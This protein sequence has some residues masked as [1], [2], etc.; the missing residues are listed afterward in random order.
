MT[1]VFLIFVVILSWYLAGVIHSFSLMMYS[2]CIVIFMFSMYIITRIYK[3]NIE[4]AFDSE[5][6]SVLKENEYPVRINVKNSSGMPIS[7]I[8][9]DI[10]V[11]YGFYGNKT[12]Y[13]SKYRVYGGCRHKKDV[14]QFMLNMPYSGPACVYIS[15]IYLYD[16]SGVFRV[17]LNP[18][19]YMNITVLPDIRSG[20]KSIET[21]INESDSTQEL[22]INKVG[23]SINDIRQ[24]R[25]YQMGD[26]YRHIHWNL[27]A[28][29]GNL[30]VKE[31][32]Q[33]T[34][35]EMNVVLEV[36]LDVI[37]D[38]KKMGVFYDKLADET[39]KLLGDNNVINI[40]W[41]NYEYDSFVKYPVR[42]KVDCE[43]VLYE[44]FLYHE[45]YRQDD[46][47]KSLNKTIPYEYSKTN[48]VRI[49]TALEV[50]INGVKI[51]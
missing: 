28:R 33:E 31:F 5:Y 37:N 51:S 44:L 40:M 16:Y 4:F 50:F 10:K 18:D 13:V 21:L 6:M 35:I 25:E 23:N 48:I 12:S 43:D 14:I 32:S 1:K 42:K 24:I 41:Y 27:S 34:D 47:R 2:I 11:M 39:V 7:R 20:R 9:L 8:R 45:K 38:Y 15:N 36:S 3:K 19:T 17:K 26:S 30:L 29:T 22:Y 46:N 49:N